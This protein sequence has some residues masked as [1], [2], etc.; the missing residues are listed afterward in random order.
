M[1][2][3]ELN[4]VI[5]GHSGAGKSSLINMLCPGANADTSNDTSGCTKE[6]HEYEC[7]LGPQQSC[8]LHDT[9]GLEEGFWGFLWAPKAEKQLKKYLKKIKPHLLVYCMPGTRNGLKK[10]HGRNFNKFKSMVGSRV[11]VVVVVTHVDSEN[12]DNPEDWWTSASLNVLRKFDIP[13]S[14]RH[15]CVSTLPKVDV[16]PGVHETS[17]EAV[18]AL[19]RNNL[20]SH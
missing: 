8:Q 15:V 14:T 16:D 5:F 17:R 12:F 20:P 18:I 13:E 4:V 9:I 6:E 19:I 2:R 3:N 11:R 7:V 10:S 1:S